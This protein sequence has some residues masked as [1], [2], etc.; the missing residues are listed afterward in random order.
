MENEINFNFGTLKVAQLGFVYRDARKQAEIMESFFGI[1]K[2][3]ILGPVEME[4]IY[5]GRETKW[6]AL[7]AFGRLFNN[8]EIELIQYESGESI[9][10]EFLDDG[11]EGFHHIR[12]DVDDIQAVIKKFKEEGIEVLQTG[13]IVS[14]TY[15]YMDTESIVGIIL[16]FSDRGTRNR[17]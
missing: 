3:T 10:K 17:K 9:H 12:Y 16:E 8:I 1:P 2:F 15:A 11:R 5:R 14:S 6:S 13:K 4:I 7:G